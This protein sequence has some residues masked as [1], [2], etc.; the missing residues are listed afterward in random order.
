MK[1]I[2]YKE[3]IKIVVSIFIFATIFTG[4]LSLLPEFN[5]FSLV[6]AGR[7]SFSWNGHDRDKA[8]REENRKRD[9]IH[10]YYRDGCILV[11][12]TDGNRRPIGDSYRWV[13]K[14]H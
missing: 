5:E 11:Y 10:R 14:T 3:R 7:R 4:F 6:H 13:K 9:T 2:L 12:N 1:N 8:Y